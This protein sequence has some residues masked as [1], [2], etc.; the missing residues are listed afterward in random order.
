MAQCFNWAL[1]GIL[2]LQVYIYWLRFPKDLSYIK[3]L[4]YIVFLLD[5]FFMAT[6]TH[7]AWQVLVQNWGDINILHLLPWT[8][9]MVP[10]G[11]GV[12]E[13]PPTQNG[14]LRYLFLF[15]LQYLASC[16]SSSSGG[17]GSLAS[18]GTCQ[19]SSPSSPSRNVHS[20]SRLDLS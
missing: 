17:F 13:S 9:A 2:C 14:Y 6:I 1:Y 7:A 19:S 10:V 12:G 15:S 8:W 11:T 4:V 5:T 20:Q 18:R 16:S 3:A